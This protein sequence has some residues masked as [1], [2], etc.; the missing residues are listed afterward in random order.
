MK[1]QNSAV[2]F[3]AHNSELKFRESFQMTH[4]RLSRLFYKVLDTNLINIGFSMTFIGF[5]SSLCTLT[6]KMYAIA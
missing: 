1:L 3:Y 5:F 4:S 2:I 6:K